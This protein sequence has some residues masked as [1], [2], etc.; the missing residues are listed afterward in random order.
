MRYTILIF[1]VI[2]DD[3]LISQTV[4][5]NTIAGSVPN[6]QVSIDSGMESAAVEIMPPVSSSYR[7][8]DH[9]QYSHQK[10]DLLLVP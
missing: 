3:T 6:V 8:P 9:Y 4:P 7:T 10:G 2:K 1:R 5:S